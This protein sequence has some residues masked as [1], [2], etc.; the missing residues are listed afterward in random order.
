MNDLAEREEVIWQ[1][2][3]TL[4]G[5]K[6]SKP[7]DQAV[8]QLTKLKELYAWR[9]SLPVF[10]DKLG[11]MLDRY[12]NRPGLKDRIHRANLLDQNPSPA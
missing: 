1:E 5:M 12:R 3:E 8:E 7:Y 2:I 11:T 9:K 6:Q 4:I 10:R